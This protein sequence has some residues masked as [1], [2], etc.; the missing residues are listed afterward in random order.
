M[1]LFFSSRQIAIFH[2]ADL[3]GRTFREPLRRDQPGLAVPANK[4]SFFISSFCSRRIRLKNVRSPTVPH[5]GLSVS[6]AY[7]SP[8][9]NPYSNSIRR[10]ALSPQA[11][12]SK[13]PDGIRTPIPSAPSDDANRTT[14][15]DRFGRCL[16]IEEHWKP[17]MPKMCTLCKM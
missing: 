15:V 17:E 7:R 10:A 1:T 5:V 14:A 11:P 4:V 6:R 16:K 12:N 8:S 2:R 9:G 13:R 3:A